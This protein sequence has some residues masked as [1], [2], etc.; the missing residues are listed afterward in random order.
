MKNVSAPSKPSQKIKAPDFYLSSSDFSSDSED[1]RGEGL[2]SDSEEKELSVD[3]LNFIN[4]ELMPTSIQFADKQANII[5]E[6]SGDGFINQYVNGRA[7]S[8]HPQSIA[9]PGKN[10]LGF[11]MGNFG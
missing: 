3:S 6:E 4:P 11:L 7:Y 9:S 1:D 8:N 5:L 10:D 2:D